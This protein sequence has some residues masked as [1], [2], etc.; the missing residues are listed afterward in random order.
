MK[1][2]L[3]MNRRAFAAMTAGLAAGI[4]GGAFAQP[5]ESAT[6]DGFTALRDKPLR[7]GMLI[8]PR[9]DQIDFTGPFSVLARMPNVKIHAIGTRKTPMAD[10]LGLILTPEFGIA[11]APEIDLLV[12]TG[13]P[14]QEALMEDAP[15]LA[16]I[17]KHWAAAKPIFSVCTGVLICGAAGI[18]KGRRATTHWAAFDLLHYFGATPIKDRVVIDGNLVSAAG[19]T[20]GID[21]ALRVAALLRGDEIAKRIELD[22]Q[23]APEPP[24]RTGLP[25][26]APPAVL[27]AVKAKYQP[28]TDAR[29]ATARKAAVR[30]GIKPAA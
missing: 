24:F 17:A 3:P 15:T 30:L 16:F 27:A 23:Y 11:D 14:G 5:M 18:L 21:G 26:T 28:V 8:F 19:L 2:R 13:G 7:I 25:E 22:L 9:L 4:A 29:L 10:H 6:A 12:V 20:A 1:D